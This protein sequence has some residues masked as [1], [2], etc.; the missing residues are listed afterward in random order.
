MES[1]PQ[2]VVNPATAQAI[3]QQNRAILSARARGGT[4]WFFW[5][6]AL[7][8]INTVTSFFN[9]Q[10]SFI[11]GL[12]ITQIMDGLA[13]GLSKELSDSGRLIVLIIA[14]CVNLGIAGLFMLAG[15]LARKRQRWIIIIGMVLYALDALIFLFFQGWIALLFHGWALWNIWNG[16]QMINKLNALEQQASQFTASQF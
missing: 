4:D 14:F 1:Q 16:L 9:I 6:A 13:L 5:I 11:A 10:F 8:L 7:S 15:F 3:L 2:S 12:A